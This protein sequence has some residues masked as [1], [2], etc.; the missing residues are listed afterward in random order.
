MSTPPT[1]LSN[2]I[3]LPPD[4]ITASYSESSPPELF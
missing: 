3:L 2:T 4:P 1:M